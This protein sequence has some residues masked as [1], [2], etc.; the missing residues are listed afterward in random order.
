MQQYPGRF[1]RGLFHSDGCRI[2]NWTERRVGGKT[3]RYEYPRYFFTN[4]SDDI[5]RLCEWALDLVGVDHRRANRRNVSVARRN[6]VALL[7]VHV[8]PKS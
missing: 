2:I 6:S 4:Y 5:L 8:G 1:L 3:K 7:D